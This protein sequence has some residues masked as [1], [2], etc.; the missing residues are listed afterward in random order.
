MA[1]HCVH[2]DDDDDGVE[3][4]RRWTTNEKCLLRDDRIKDSDNSIDFLYFFF[5]DCTRRHKISGHVLYDFTVLQNPVTFVL[6]GRFVTFI[7]LFIYF[8]A[9]FCPVFAS[10]CKWH[11]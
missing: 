9:H 8:T 10:L 4:V 11:L 7:Y 6:K 1:G 2:D 5:L 3:R